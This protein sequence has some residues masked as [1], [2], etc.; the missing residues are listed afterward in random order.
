MEHSLHV[1]HMYEA[2]YDAYAGWRVPNSE[3]FDQNSGSICLLHNIRLDKAWRGN[4]IALL[5]VEALF[6]AGSQPN[7]EIAVLRP[8]ALEEA[9]CV[10]PK[11]AMKKLAD[12]WAILGFAPC[13][14]KMNGEDEVEDMYMSLPSVEEIH[15]RQ[16]VPHLFPRTRKYVRKDTVW[17]DD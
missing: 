11:A 15:L 3:S 13:A 12:H 8:R 9:E 6:R 2:L 4:G 16:A 17:K 7:H 5:A 14:T 10:C 1:Q